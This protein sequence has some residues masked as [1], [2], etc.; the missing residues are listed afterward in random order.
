MALGTAGGHTRH[1]AAVG[2]EHLRDFSA[3]ARLCQN[4]DS[5][6]SKQFVGKSWGGQNSSLRAF[7]KGSFESI[8][9]TF[10]G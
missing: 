7:L 6:A 9:L 10:S 2:E 4:A 5:R 3:E 8:L 1:C